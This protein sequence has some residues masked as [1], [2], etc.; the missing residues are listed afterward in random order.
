[1]QI[2]TRGRYAVVVF[3][4]DAAVGEVMM[5]KLG[6]DWVMLTL[7]DFTSRCMFEYVV[8]ESEYELTYLHSASM[9]RG[10]AV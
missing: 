2:G 9:W 8:L 1:M 10:G 7:A 4:K 3:D 6:E 5:L